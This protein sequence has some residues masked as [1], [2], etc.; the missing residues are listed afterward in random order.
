MAY[1]CGVAACSQ[2]VCVL[3]VCV[4]LLVTGTAASTWSACLSGPVR[5]RVE[6]V[7]AL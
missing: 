7:Q 4:R 6:P 1:G 2:I 3:C 5:D